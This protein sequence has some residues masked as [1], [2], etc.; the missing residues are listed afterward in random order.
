MQEKRKNIS[1]VK[2]RILQFVET[3]N[4]KKE[5]FYQETSL[6]GANFRG[7]SAESEL[8]CDKIAIILRVYDDLNPDWLL[9]GKGQM[10]RTDSTSETTSP[11]QSDNPA[12]N[13]LDNPD[14]HIIELQDKL[15]KQLEH[16]I[17]TI[18]SEND[19]LRV[20]IAELQKQLKKKVATN[21]ATTP[22]L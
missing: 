14:K 18:E 20:E 12:S 15:I 7:K 11:T 6:C 16:R 22:K 2:Q 9:L 13:P 4:I 17:E 21:T 1:Q 5:K 8:S 3:M 10:L 19:N